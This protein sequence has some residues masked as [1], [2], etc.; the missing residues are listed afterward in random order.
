MTWQL[1]VR[2]ADG[3][4]QVASLED[5]TRHE[6]EHTIRTDALAQTLTRDL[7]WRLTKLQPC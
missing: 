7:P 2:D 1:W 6:A 3:W 5:G 4:R